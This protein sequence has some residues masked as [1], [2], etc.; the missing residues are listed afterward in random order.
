MSDVLKVEG[1]TKPRRRSS[2]A[3]QIAGKVDTS[4]YEADSDQSPVS[5]DSLTAL[6]GLA[7][8]LLDREADVG[9][10][11]RKLKEAMEAL[12]DVQ[13]RRLP[14]LLEE[15][16]IPK[17]EFVDRTTG[18]RYSIKLDTNWRVSMPPMKDEDGNPLPE[19]FAKR[20]NVFAWAREIGQ[21]GSVKKNAEVALGLV[22]DEFAV[23]FITEIKKNYPNLDPAITEKIEPAT[24]TAMVRRLLEAGKSVCEDLVVKPVRRAKVTEK[25]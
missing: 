6:Q 21:G 1:A 23:K 8:E 9:R 17:F 11:G 12:E 14:D 3:G 2:L 10:A 22:S 13:E 25:K 16:N 15:H 19:N 18:I 24:L 20:K 4:A 7:Q 5:G